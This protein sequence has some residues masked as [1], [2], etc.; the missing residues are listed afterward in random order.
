MNRYSLVQRGT[1][2]RIKLRTTCLCFLFVFVFF[3]TIW[4]LVHKDFKKRGWS[5]TLVGPQSLLFEPVT[6]DSEPSMVR[7]AQ[8][9]LARLGLYSGLIDGKAGKKTL[10]AQGIYLHNIIKGVKYD[11]GYSGYGYSWESDSQTVS[12]CK[13]D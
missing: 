5:F 4:F 10:N 8:A 11:S 3:G 13:D 6:I 2:R 12:S 9:E 7:T 1:E